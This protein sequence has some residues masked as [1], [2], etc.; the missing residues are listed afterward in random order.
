MEKYKMSS[1]QNDIKIYN[2]IEEALLAPEEKIRIDLQGKR[3]KSLPKG[4]EAL[5]KIPY[6]ELDLSYN[7]ALQIDVVLTQLVQLKNLR[8]LALMR[9]EF[10]NLPSDIGKLI[11]LESLTL[12]GNKSTKLPPEFAQL[13]QLKYLILRTNLFK[14]IPSQINNFKHLGYLEM[15]Y[16]PIKEI[17]SEFCQNMGGSLQ[18]LILKN[19]AFKRLPEAI[20]ELKS[21]RSLNLREND[22]HSFPDGIKQLTNLQEIYYYGNDRLKKEDLLDVHASLLQLKSLSLSGYGLKELPAFVSQMKKLEVLN[23]QQNDLQ[24]LPDSLGEMPYLRELNIENNPNFS[25]STIWNAIEEGKYQ[26]LNKDK[27]PKIDRNTEGGTF[28]SPEIVELS[29]NLKDYPI[30]PSEIVKLEKL[31]R[32]DISFYDGENKDA[33][34]T[35]LPDFFDQFE[36]LETLSISNINT[37]KNLPPSVYRSLTLTSISCYGLSNIALDFEALSKMTSLSS[38]SC[39]ISDNDAPYLPLLNNL[40]YLG[41]SNSSLTELPD[42]MIH[43]TK[44]SS[45]SFDGLPQLNLDDAIEKLPYIESFSSYSIRKMPQNLYRLPHLKRLDVYQVPFNEVLDFVEKSESIQELTYQTSERTIPNNIHILNKLKKCQITNNYSWSDKSVIQLSSNFALL[46][47]EKVDLSRFYG[48]ELA[49][50]SVEKIKGFQLEKDFQKKIAFALLMGRFDEI[51]E[52]LENPFVSNPTLRGVSIYIFGT[53]TFSTLK[54][55]QENLTSR[56]AQIS[57]KLDNTVSHIL[58]SSKVKDDIEDIMKANKPF[59][60]EDY[61]KAQVFSEDMP[62]LMEDVNEELVTQITR[63]LKSTDG[64]NSISLMLE[65]IEGGGA[66]KIIL[67]YLYVI[68]LFHDDLAVRK[69]SRKLFRK[70]A[71]TELQTFLKNTWKDGLKHREH[72]HIFIHDDLDFFACILAA[73]MVKFNLANKNAINEQ[74]TL[75]ELS[76]L[77]LNSSLFTEFSP[78]FADL[79]FITHIH[80]QGNG[81]IFNLKKSYPFFKENNIASLIF[82]NLK[83]EEFPIELFQFPN[84]E[85]LS[86]ACHSENKT[87]TIA[88]PDLPKLIKLKNLTFQNIDFEN[89]ENLKSIIENLERLDLTNTNLQCHLSLFECAKGLKS[90]SCHNNAEVT[91][92]NINFSNF[93]AINDI[94]IS[95]MPI[96][97]IEDNF[98]DCLKIEGVYI[99]NTHISV[100]PYSLLCIGKESE[101]SNIVIKISESKIVEIGKPINPSNNQI[102]IK[103]NFRLILENNALPEIPPVLSQLN[104]EELNFDRNPITKLPDDIDSYK[105]KDWLRLHSTKITDIPLSL[106]KLTARVDVTNNNEDMVLPDFDMIPPFKGR[107]YFYG[108]N[109]EKFNK[110]NHLINSKCTN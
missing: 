110:L 4:Y 26:R 47:F 65:L 60:L 10:G 100:M 98:Y 95:N 46:D 63:L 5:G 48:I 75:S 49:Q 37:L 23:V 68:H 96:E 25:L 31:K 52:L 11:G 99:S 40:S 41:L 70:Y 18:S 27:L 33:N 64:D 28:F 88:I 92:L 29:L 103:N 7:T 90:F 38:L 54:E 36:A 9:I 3:L 105:I 102:N 32:L 106:F 101:R 73:K 83:F 22:L 51:S 93:K 78:S 61:F 89:I 12:W 50:K 67:S 20:K 109:Y 85:L 104:F 34:I 6:L 57:K 108:K 15:S 86:L 97:S 17:S 55:L 53:P 13:E 44:L 72:N 81:Q 35:E 21:L 71:S 42:G 66:N 8:G 69:K 16:C 87:S 59:I 19:C 91:S 84:L 43:L 58:L 107:K 2:S 14:E 77:R 30:F 45:F 79:D 82:S 56:G 80:F 24:T 39:S 62:Y 94:Y 76:T 1:I 74:W